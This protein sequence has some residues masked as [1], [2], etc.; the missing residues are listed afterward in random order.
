MLKTTLFKNF[1]VGDRIYNSW[2]A[3]LDSI[4]EIDINSFGNVI[5]VIEHKWYEPH[6]GN[7][8]ISYSYL[9]KLDGGNIIEVGYNIV[10]VTRLFNFLSERKQEIENILDDLA[11]LITNKI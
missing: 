8:E 6:H 1:E 9:I 4:H 3:N 2:E 11:N 7:E 5:E 10:N